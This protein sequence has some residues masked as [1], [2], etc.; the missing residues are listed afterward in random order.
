M[1]KGRLISFSDQN[2]HFYH[3]QCILDIAVVFAHVQV[4]LDISP[5]LAVGISFQKLANEPHMVCCQRASDW[6]DGFIFSNKTDALTL[7]PAFNSSCETSRDSDW[8]DAEHTL[9]LSK[10]LDCIAD[11]CQNLRRLSI[12][13][14]D[15]ARDVSLFDSR[16][17]RELKRLE[18]LE[19]RRFKDYNLDC[20][21]VSLRSVILEYGQ[22]WVRDILSSHSIS[23]LS[24]PVHSKLEYLEVRK[25]GTL[26]LIARQ[27]TEQCKTVHVDA[28]Y[29]L[30]GVT[31]SG[32]RL[33]SFLSKCIFIL[34]CE[35]EYCIGLRQNKTKKTNKKYSTSSN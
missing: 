3:S 23:V 22:V 13:L 9:L 10:S 14:P 26:G 33:V 4:M 31:V 27:L 8:N 28:L 32:M 25:S 11:R 35:V 18:R 19:L 30:L 16:W 20:L 7:Y 5:K 34:S 2:D 6:S 1:G 24:L 21:P 17:I 15:A 12:L 29:L